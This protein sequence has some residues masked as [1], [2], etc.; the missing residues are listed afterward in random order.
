MSPAFDLVLDEEVAW[1]T[2]RAGERSVPVL[3]EETLELLERTLDE[4]AS[5]PGLLGVAFCSAHPGIFLAGADLAMI[6]GMREPQAAEEMCRRGQAVFNRLAGL[7]FPTAALIEGACLGG[8]LELAL[9]CTYRLAS[10]EG[11]VRLGLPEV[12]LGILPGLGGTQR[13]PRLVGLPAALGLVLSGRTIPGGRALKMGLVDEVVPQVYLRHRAVELLER[14]KRR[15]KLPLRAR[16]LT[17]SP[18]RRAV[19]ASARRRLLRQTHG[20]YPAPLEALRVVGEGL[21]AGWERGLG[22]EARA[23]AGLVG[24][25]VCRNLLD[26]YFLNERFKKGDR[27]GEAASLRE[28]A[29]VGAGTMGSGLAY[30]LS[31]RG[32]EV[33]LADLDPKMLTRAMQRCDGWYRKAVR[34]GVIDAR[35]A[36]RGLRRIA[37]VAAGGS[38]DLRRIRRAELAVEAVVEDLEVK[39]RLFRDLETYL[40]EEA[41]LA[42]NTSALS[43]AAMAEGLKRPERLVG[44]HFF[45]PVHRMPLV[46]VVA[47]AGTSAEVLARS[48]GWVRSWGKTPLEVR[49]RPGFL[50]NRLL[51]PYLME[52]VEFY[53]DGVP[54]RLIDGALERFGMPMG[55][56]KLL[57]AV[58]LPLSVKV[59]RVMEDA[60]GVRMRPCAELEELIEHRFGFYPP[61]R[62]ERLREEREAF[63]EERDLRERMLFRMV[64]EA[65]F[66][67]EEGVVSAP[68]EVDLAM[69][70]GAGFPPFRG[71]LLRWADET[72]LGRIRD[73]LRRW[74]EAHGAR[75]ALCGILDC[76]SPRRFYP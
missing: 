8:G 7:R 16:L 23:F 6:S 10:R 47:H 62:A 71:G 52:A 29:V 59:A 37:P 50:V 46:E 68:E 14:G 3:G 63:P 31:F 1:I 30:W 19:M 2:F 24:G 39:R 74:A 67:L 35:E 34:A 18:V 15:R 48:M 20:H 21:Q 51:S 9:A 43:V 40:P 70:L 57:D 61:R 26:F 54:V 58:G 38:G 69:T 44:L 42:T 25:P 22:A 4:L 75:F 13:L 33:T 76:D 12:S 36:D 49:D 32:V 11:K 45:N 17:Y 27:K 72:G 53:A 65:G 60:F 64:N 73:R 28:A 55:P 56:L 5:R 66:C 41:V